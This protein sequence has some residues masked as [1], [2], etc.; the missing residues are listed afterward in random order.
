MA[1]S[2]AR[3]LDY[4]DD[5]LGGVEADALLQLQLPN[6]ATAAVEWSRTRNLRNTAILTGSRWQIEVSLHR[7]EIMRARPDKLTLFELDG[8]SGAKICSSERSQTGY[9][10]SA[11][12]ESPSFPALRRQ[13]QSA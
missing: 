6:G 7:N 8:R 5:S 2:E 11:L 9:R 13:S 4:Q 1:N 10:Q 12:V 3:A